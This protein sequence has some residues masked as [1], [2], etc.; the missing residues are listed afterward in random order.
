[1]KTIITIQ[2]TH[3][4]SCKALIEDVCSE[5][6]GINRCTVDYKS[7]RTEIAHDDTIDWSLLEREVA[8]VGPYVVAYRGG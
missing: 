8:S 7:G 5:I 3:C 2:G 4:E 6:P 1:M